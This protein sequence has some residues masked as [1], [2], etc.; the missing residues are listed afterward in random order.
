MTALH[1]ADLGRRRTAA[2]LERSL[3]LAHD[4]RVEVASTVLIV[5]ALGPAALVT[6]DASRNP[7]MAMCSVRGMGVAES[8]RT[9]TDA[10]RR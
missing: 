10:F 5:P 7:A 2:P 8:V 6:S 1:H 9:S 3:H 4:R